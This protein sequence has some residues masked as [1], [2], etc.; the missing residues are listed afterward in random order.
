MMILICLLQAWVIHMD[1]DKLD[2]TKKNIGVTNMDEQ[3]R[4][5][6][7]EKF[8]DGGGKVIDEKAARKRLTID[9]E[10]QKQ[11]LKKAEI[12]ANRGRRVEKQRQVDQKQVVQQRPPATGD[13]GP[14][15]LFFNRLK[16][17]IK[18][19]TSGVAGFNG[20]FFDA[21]F[22]KKFNNT[23]KPAMMELQILFLEIFRKSPATG[24]EITS[25]LDKIKPLYYELIEMIGNLFD[26]IMADQIV[27]QYINF[28]EVPKKTGELKGQILLLYKKLH[29]L[30]RYEHSILSAFEM[31]IDLYLKKGEK[32]SDSFSSMR[33]SARNDLFVVFH[34]LYPRL[35]LLFC[36]YQWRLYPQSDPAIDG[37]LGVLDE[38][39]PGNRQ[40][41]R[42]FEESSVTVTGPENTEADEEL[43]KPD[44]ARA[45]ALRK[46]LELM[47][48]ID[49]ARLRKEYDRTRLFE[50]V[51]EG[52]KVFLTY[53]LFNE[54]D[55]EYSF[56]LTTSKIKFR[57]DFIA[58]TKIDFRSRLNVLYDRMK[59]SSDGLKEY[60]EELG[61]YE[62]ARREK[63]SSNAQYIEF[64]KR[65]ESFEKKK[66]AA[67]KNALAMVRQYM[68]EVAEELALLMDDMDGNQIYVENP[69]EEIVFDTLIEG[70]KKL[71][72]KK[73]FEAIH[74]AYS[75][76]FAFASRLSQGGDLS[77]DLE[78]KKE[79]LDELRKRME[80]QAAMARE[81][82]EREEKKSVLEELDDML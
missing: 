14:L 62:K 50:N 38:E 69:Q 12:H 43:E 80:E 53:L 72:G 36:L 58:R 13:I 60:A 49:F 64:T 30:S 15:A 46:G 18:L 31:A 65:M 1:K 34:K 76:A 29:L 81:E 33:K 78:F 27:E 71:N 35:H 32:S 40:L 48:M 41:E 54:F 5:N 37:I 26:K 56:I 79:E 9:R 52:D 19:K 47:S 10:K 55:R 45:K 70:E 51:G 66:T 68:T 24:R 2:K 3:T 77:G 39:K 7:F 82:S 74:I 67:G 22:F 20:Y 42:Y 63:P 11:F 8:V 44:D 75:Y 61:S 25:R 17:R 6:L 21:R 57:T 28:P 23:Y 73:V 59:K 16:L 4:K